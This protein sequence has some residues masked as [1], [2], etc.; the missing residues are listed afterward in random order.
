MHS[1]DMDIRLSPFVVPRGGP[2]LLVGLLFL[3]ASPVRASDITDYTVLKAQLFT[4][5]NL[6]TPAL[7][8]SNEYVIHAFADLCFPDAA[9]VG[10]LQLPGGMITNL[11][12][13]YESFSF[14][15]QF[16]SLAALNAAYPSGNYLFTL[17]TSHFGTNAGAL[18][19][20]GDGYPANAPRLT[21]F[22]AA[23]A[24]NPAM[25]FR[26]VWDA[27]TGGTTND[28]ILAQVDNDFGDT[29]FVTSTVRGQG[30]FL[31]GTNTSVIIPGKTLELGQTYDLRLVFAKISSSNTTS[32]AGTTGLAGYAKRTRLTIRTTDVDYFGAVKGQSFNQTSAA[33]PVSSGY[34]FQAFIDSH[35]AGTVLSATVQLPSGGGT[36]TL[37]PENDFSLGADYA[38]QAAMDAAYPNG[39][40]TMTIN[41]ADDGNRVAVL[42]T[43]LNTYPA[44]TPRVSNFSV[45]QAINSGTDFRL[46]W[47]AFSGGTTN[48]FIQVQIDDPFQ[49]DS[50]L[51]ETGQPGEPNAL[52]GTNV[53]CVIPAGTLPGGQSYNLTLLYGKLNRTNSYTNVVGFGGYFK[54]TQCPVTTAD[55][56][57]YGVVK[58]QVYLQ[59][60]ASAPVL[61]EYNLSVFVETDNG[62]NVGSASLKLPDNSIQPIS[63]GGDGFFLQAGPYA[64]QAALDAA[65]TNGSYT[66]NIGAVHDG[67]K[68]LPLTLTGNTYPATTPHI[69]N[70]A[71]AQ[72]IDP[73]ANFTLAWDAF[74]GGTTNDYIQVEIDAAGGSGN[75]LF[76]TAHFVGQPGALNGTNISVVIPRNTLM[77]GRSYDGRLLFVRGV[78]NSNSYTGVLGVGGYHKQTQ[79]TLKT[80]GTAIRPHLDLTADFQFGS[81]VY[82]HLTGEI[83]QDYTIEW[84]EDLKNPSW[85]PLI[86]FT[87]YD[88]TFDWYDNPP[89]NSAR[90]YYRV[91]EGQ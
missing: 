52:N 74:S 30:I 56:N 72:A 34:S 40:Y 51:F 37:P 7:E 35:F 78:V 11:S 70:F 16:N 36:Q 44:T 15:A 54:Q 88:G 63:G 46:T 61:Q 87:A 82:L 26:L 67:A 17:R 71:A 33:A 45:A 24:I 13:S 8:A 76:Q 20:T 49:T 47:D 68:A 39:N 6:S 84:T 66:L 42:N 31:N 81:Q 10:T 29:V 80:T 41:T 12:A 2:L 28:F 64:S 85:S 14:D 1:I 18:T 86:S 89:G 9:A 79:F 19:L 59:T 73:C 58:G 43:S 25:D 57:F 53:F 21:N 91:H 65:Y 83:N 32:I 48:D 27:M 38:T 62:E 75:S 90:R 5:T 50:H 60:N 77:P 22:V 3:S 23:Q 4:Q 55:I 69:S